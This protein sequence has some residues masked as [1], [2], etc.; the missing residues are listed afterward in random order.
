M[1]IAKLH[2]MP[3]PNFIKKAINGTPI[4]IPRTRPTNISIP[5]H[6]NKNLKNL[7]KLFLLMNN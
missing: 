2:K 3:M 4:K 5:I 7:K 6:P 1:Y